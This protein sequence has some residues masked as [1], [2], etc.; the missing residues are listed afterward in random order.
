MK[1]GG[2][3]RTLP[4]TFRGA[5][6]NMLNQPYIIMCIVAISLF[7][8]TLMITSILDAMHGKSLDG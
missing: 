6:M 1:S 5:D 7:S 8:A 3:Y 2:Q 4:S